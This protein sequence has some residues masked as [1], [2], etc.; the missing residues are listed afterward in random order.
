[1]NKL[2]RRLFLNFS[3]QFIFIA[4]SMTLI[5]LIVT[6]IAMIWVFQNEQ[7]EDYYQ[8]ILEHIALNAG[9]NSIYELKFTEDWGDE[10]SDDIWIQ[11]IDEEGKVIGSQNT[12]NEL[13]TSY[14]MIDLLQINETK[15]YNTY[16]LNVYL[17]TFY[18]ENYLF[19]LG[20]EDQGQLLMSEL[21]EHYNTNG[22]IDP[23]AITEVEAALQQAGG[24]LE[25]YNDQSELVQ[26]LGEMEHEEQPLSIFSRDKSPDLFTMNQYMFSDPQTNSLWLLYTPNQH[27][28]ELPLHSFRQMVLGFAV[29]GVV[30]LIFTIMIAIWHGFRYGKPLFIFA[31]WLGRMGD[32][33]YEEV[34]TAREKKQVYRKNGKIKRRYRLYQEVFQA[35]YDMAEKLNVSR[36][37]REKLEKTREE[38]MAGI[39]HDLRTPLTSMEGY[40]RLLAS[41]EYDWSKQELKEIGQTIHE[42]SE[43]MVHLIEDFTLSFQL[44]NDAALA[45]FELADINAFMKRIL[46]KFTSDLTFKE[47]SVTFHPLA[48]P[49]E[50]TLNERLFERMVDNLIY[51]ALKHNPPG[52]VIT[53]E[54]KKEDGI[55]VVITDNGQGMDEETKEHLFH[56]YYRG[57]NTEEREEG[58]GLGMSIALQ[59]AKL[60][61]G[62]ISVESELGQ[63]TT[64]TVHFPAD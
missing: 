22:Q 20:Y 37:E 31:N 11:V 60:H 14:S 58:T 48:E 51:N 54:L 41:G 59:I 43:Y 46:G 25:I 28:Q 29:I 36:K 49:E 19:V 3:I 32:G 8:A 40:G 10:L 50:M 17:E 13:P 23:S 1:M 62:S 63:G 16:S 39:S 30:V 4:V 42:K 18:E 6:L 26:Q 57:T 21:V 2:R 38:W 53:V 27:K 44:K 52:T 64:I 12:P 34:L 45:S 9:G 15:Q 7:S 56:R 24:T 55:K 47:Y 35:F 61:Q 5:I 33:P